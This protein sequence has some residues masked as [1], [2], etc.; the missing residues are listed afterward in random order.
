VTTAT[1]GH[2]LA[3]G[4]N[5]GDAGQY[6]ALPTGHW[7]VM[8]RHGGTSSPVALD[9]ASASVSTV[10]V[11]AEPGGGLGLSQLRDSTGVADMPVGAAA[12]GGGGTAPGSVP[13]LPALVVA[14]TV[15]SATL[16]VSR[17]STRSPAGRGGRRARV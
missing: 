15:G 17:R 8:L 6:V 11:L 9:V 14:V 10:V 12:T 16:L 13:L 3:T 5:Y 1:G 4:L 2:T 7:N